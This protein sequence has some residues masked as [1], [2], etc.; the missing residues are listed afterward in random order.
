MFSDTN[1]IKATVFSQRLKK[2]VDRYNARNDLGKTQAVVDDVV[3]GLSAELQ[4]IFSDL[5]TEQNSYQ[6]LGITYDEKA[7]YD[8]LI[9]VAEKH[10]FKEQLSEDKY[11]YLANEIKKHVA[12][13]SKY[14]DWTTAKMSRMS[15]IRM[16][17]FCSTKT[18]SHRSR[19]MR[20]MTR[21]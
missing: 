8:I 14:T 18:D 4:K 6:E 17:R 9:S 11:I 12:N 19:L 15:F 20:L 13:K 1:N 21:L 16:L 2:V 7:F 3:D 5:K 10:Q